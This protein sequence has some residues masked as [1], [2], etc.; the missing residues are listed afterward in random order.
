MLWLTMAGW[1][2]AIPAEPKHKARCAIDGQYRNRFEQ[3]DLTAPALALARQGKSWFSCQVC[4]TC[5][6][7]RRG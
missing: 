6:D 3:V 4:G 7:E 5:G 1:Q 2:G